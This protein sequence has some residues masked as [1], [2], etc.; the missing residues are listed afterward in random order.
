MS[1]NDSIIDLM[2]REHRLREEK[3][4]LKM[5]LRCALEWIEAVPDDTAQTLPAMPG[6]DWDWAKSPLEP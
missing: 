5:A 2:N 6:F 1:T 4:Q 3:K